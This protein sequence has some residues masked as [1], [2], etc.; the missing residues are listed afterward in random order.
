MAGVGGGGAAAAAVEAFI[1]RVCASHVDVSTRA[2][3]A[4][5]AAGGGRELAPHPQNEANQAKMAQ[6]KKAY[7]VIRRE[8]VERMAVGERYEGWHDRRDG[9]RAEVAA[10][11]GVGE[12]AKEL[13]LA[14]LRLGEGPRTMG[15]AVRLGR[16]LLAG[17]AARDKKG[18]GK[19]VEAEADAELAAVRLKVSRPSGA[20]SYCTTLFE[21]ALTFRLHPSAIDRRLQADHPPP[22]VLRPPRPRL[23]RRPL[24]PDPR[25]PRGRRQPRPRSRNRCLGRAGRGRPGTGWRQAG[26]RDGDRWRGPNSDGR[27]ARSEGPA[28]GH[29]GGRPEKQ[30]SG[31]RPGLSPF[32]Q[33]L[34]RGR[35]V[36]RGVIAWFVSVL[37]CVGRAGLLAWSRGSAFLFV[38]AF[39]DIIHLLTFPHPFHR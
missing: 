20:G 9:R 16:E 18:K 6:L 25:R 19:E 31:M 13:S 24:G 39:S 5:G 21:N 3:E 14:G 7:D 35:E 27:G 30:G 2:A 1:G 28:E 12:E 15:E 29:F 17:T 22:V 32:V 8:E 4:S 23:R 10:A 36:G 34:V 37:G 11:M 33:S 26:A 38:C